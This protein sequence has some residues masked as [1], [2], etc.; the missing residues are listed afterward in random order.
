MSVAPAVKADSKTSPEK[1]LASFEERYFN[2]I[3]LCRKAAE[4]TASEAW[5]A[6]YSL[7]LDNHR[8]VIAS[9]RKTIEGTCE[10]I[11]RGD[12][13]EDAEKEIRDCAKAMGEERVRFEAWKSRAVVPYSKAVDDCRLIRED[14]IRSAKND[15]Q[16]GPLLNKGLASA[17][18]DLVKSWPV[19]KWDEDKGVLTTGE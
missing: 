5:Q 19:P 1:W 7:Q 11:K 6:N 12:T 13:S 4:T 15:E 8:K 2:V 17:V 16:A 10:I 18:G 3:G 9:Q 14:A